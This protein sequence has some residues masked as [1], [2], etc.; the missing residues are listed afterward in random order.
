M[1][2]LGDFKAALHELRPSQGPV[3][4]KPDSAI[5]WIV[6]FSTFVKMA[7][8]LRNCHDLAYTNMC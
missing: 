6:I 5:H 8:D 7:K 2:N 3:V 1:L 4:R